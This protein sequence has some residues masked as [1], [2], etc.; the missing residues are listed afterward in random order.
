MRRRITLVNIDMQKDFCDPSG[1]LYVPGAEKDVDR[2]AM[3][4]EKNIRKITD[5][6]ST[7]DSH[8]LLHIGNPLWFVDGAT[9]SKHPT[10]FS[11]VRADDVKAGVWTTSRPDQIAWTLDYLQKLEASGRIHVIWPPHCIIG[12]QGHAI[13][14]KLLGAIH[15]WEETRVN[16]A[17]AV[18]KGSNPRVEH[19]SA[20]R[21]EV[22]D[23]TDPSTLMNMDLVRSIEEADEIY[24]AGEATTHCVLATVT[25]LVSN[26][27]SADAIKKTTLLIDCTS[28]VPD[29]TP[30]LFSSAMN[31][32][33]S[34]MKARGMRVCKSTDVTL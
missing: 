14:D 9:R 18:T 11:V 26:F 16:I 10:P 1:S 25:D 5:I 19:F 21:S 13:A 24:L 20:F 2:T 33:V 8:Y 4:I 7:L 17:Q 15:L 28:P 27:S 34:D 3:F 22:P 30:G 6:K 31:A 29:P 12:S 23:P 32:F